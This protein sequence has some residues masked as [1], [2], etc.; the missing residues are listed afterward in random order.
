MELISILPGPAMLKVEEFL[1]KREENQ[2]YFSMMV[3]PLLDNTVVKV[4]MYKTR[5]GDIKE[6]LNCFIFKFVS[7]GGDGNICFNCINNDNITFVELS[8]KDYQKETSYCIEKYLPL[9]KFRYFYE[10]ET[11]FMYFYNH[12]SELMRNIRQ[13]IVNRKLNYL[14]W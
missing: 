13:E 11:R 7:F 5:Y 14:K 4:G 9:G 12:Y 3:T 10:D 2:E 8:Y 1:G 6:C